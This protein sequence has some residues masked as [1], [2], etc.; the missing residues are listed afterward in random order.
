MKIT[1]NEKK[2]S[3][4][5]VEN[6]FARA[7][8]SLNGAQAMEYVP[9]GAAP[10]LWMSRES[11]FEPGR[12]IRGGVPVCF[13]WFGPNEKDFSL[14]SHGLA[15]TAVWDLA[16]AGKLP[17]GE[18]ELVFR[19][20]SS[21]WDAALRAVVGPALELTLEIANV[22]EKPRMFEE[23]LHSYFRV[24]DIESVSVSGL[25]GCKYTDKLTDSTAADGSVLRI[26][27]EVD[28]IYRSSGVCVIA[29]ERAGR[30]IVV[31]KRNSFSTVVW[32]PWV[33]KSRRMPDFGDREYRSMLCVES[34]NVKIDAITLAPGE[35]HSLSVKI[36]TRDI[37]K[38]A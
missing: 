21:W 4:V 30:E 16:S 2:M 10:V 23:A 5:E 11:Y 3:F 26:D 8:F 19:W 15:R 25:E 1:E 13:P 12:P 22:S 9:A 37:G 34:G 14:P 24:S 7:K 27:R 29:D 6:D 28:R 35:T 20:S 31:K 17:G 38:K 18:D 36:F 33:E 32:N